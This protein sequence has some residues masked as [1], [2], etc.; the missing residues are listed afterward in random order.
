MF[1]MLRALYTL[2]EIIQ[3]QDEQIKFWEKRRSA[4]RYALYE[5]Q[6]ENAELQRIC[7]MRKN[8]LSIVSS[9]STGT[10]KG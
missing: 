10:R 1:N 5:L 6:L 7:D 2:D 3:E 4:V 8:D 9:Y